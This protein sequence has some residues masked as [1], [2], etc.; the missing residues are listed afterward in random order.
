MNKSD[1]DHKIRDNFKEIK[2]NLNEENSYFK[3]SSVDELYEVWRG[4]K[5]SM[6]QVINKIDLN[7][8]QKYDH[9]IDEKLDYICSNLKLKTMNRKIGVKD[10]CLSSK[11]FLKRLRFRKD[12]KHIL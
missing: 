6:F 1:Y 9:D 12:I 4:I 3:D 7:L 8:E 10:G 11:G 2:R 5:N